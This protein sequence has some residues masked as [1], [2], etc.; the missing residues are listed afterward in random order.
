MC[1]WCHPETEPLRAE[2]NIQETKFSI[3]IEGNEIVVYRYS[4]RLNGR[5]D[6]AL[7]L[8]INFCPMCG[9]MITEDE[10]EET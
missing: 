3:G 8:P 5:A 2:Y 10:D 1:K 6:M 9:E 7:E 4:P